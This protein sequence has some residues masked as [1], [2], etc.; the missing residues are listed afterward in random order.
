MRSIVARRASVIPICASLAAAAL[1][2]P[3]GAARDASAFPSYLDAWQARYPTS[4]IP[5]RLEAGGGARCYT[6]HNPTTFGTEGTA[7]RLAIRAR[8][9]A[10]RTIQ[11]ALADIE[12]DDSDG[13]GVRNLDEI[14]RPRTDLPGQIG[15]HPGLVGNGGFDLLI[16][17]NQ[18]ITGVLESPLPRCTGDANGD[19]VTNFADL[20]LVLSRFGDTGQGIAADVNRDGVVN[21]VD[22]NIVLG[23][24]GTG[25]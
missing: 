13:D 3:G 25:C 15:F 23:A 20:N 8:L 12:Q 24:F 22:L 11:Q 4:T 17:P 1:Y 9:I 10:G 19:G 2:F 14:L 18:A 7:Y 5:A 16:N 21:F 6:C